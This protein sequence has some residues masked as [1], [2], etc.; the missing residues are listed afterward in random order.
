MIG[1]WHNAL[2]GALAVLYAVAAMVV[3]SAV[4]LLLLDAGSLGSLWSLTMTLTAMAVG[5]S[6]N[7]GAADAGDSGGMGGLGALFG[8]GGGMAPSM[9]GAA[10]AVPLGVT[11]VGAVVLWIVFSR[12]LRQGQQRRLTG[13]DLAARAA[14]AGAA[15][16]FLLMIVAGFAHGTI[17]LPEGAMSGAGGEESGAAGGLGE[18]MG[19]GGMGEMSAAPYQVSAVA[20]GFG[21]VLWVAAALGVGCLISR[22][23]RLPLGG[24]LDRLRSTW[25][26]SLSAVV[27]MVLVM[28]AVPLAALVF[29]GVAVGGRVGSVAGGA[30]LVAPNVLVVLLTLGIGSSWTAEMHP[31]TTDSS[32][33]NP[34]AGL[35][36]GSGGMGG[37]GGMMGGDMTDRTE[38]LSALSAGGLLV[39]LLAITVTGLI[40]LIPAYRAARATQSAQK[41]PML[42]Y[43]GPLAGH[44][45]MAERF[46]IVTAVFLGVATWLVGAS[47]DF[48]VGMFGSTMGGMQA[49]LSGNLLS[50]L[51][52]GLIVGALAGFAG[53]LLATWRGDRGPGARRWWSLVTLGRGDRAAQ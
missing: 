48:G 9:S 52:F 17:T 2:E 40:L 28:A 19:G 37:M 13:S 46:G 38:H 39:W 18:L 16:M 43:R 33:S 47:G 50:T 26:P 23:V 27:R 22:K 45:G 14:G 25:G 8:G 53:S 10:D 11:L 1:P 42:P 29:V 31:V 30:L 6:A 5:A 44:L 41:V 49:A 12:R 3:V 36:G 20:A 21:A 34:L 24:T 15:A 4:A 32:S 7:A 35:M 51:F